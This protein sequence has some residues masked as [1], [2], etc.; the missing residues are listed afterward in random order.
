MKNTDIFVII[1]V[2][3]LVLLYLNK[4]YES[5]TSNSYDITSN[6][7]TN[8]DWKGATL[9]KYPYYTNNLVNPPSNILNQIKELQKYQPELDG[10]TDTTYVASGM[11]I[12]K[13]LDNPNNKEGF[14]NYE[15]FSMMNPYIHN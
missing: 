10:R 12:Q 15:E 13:N 8:M 14:D 5:F 3:I 9:S 6:I 2:I 4:I 7:T 11:S 1:L